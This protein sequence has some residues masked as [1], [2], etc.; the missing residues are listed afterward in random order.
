MYTLEKSRGYSPSPPLSY[1]LILRNI[2][3]D[4]DMWYTTLI[5]VYYNNNNYFNSADNLGIA[6]W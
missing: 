5:L 6:S 1:M 3:T 4:Y 2:N